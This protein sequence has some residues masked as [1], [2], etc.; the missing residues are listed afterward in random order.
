MRYFILHENERYYLDVGKGET[1]REVKDLLRK[2]FNLDTVKNHEGTS[3]VSLQL[4]YAGSN[5]EDEWIFSDIAIQTGSTLRCTLQQKVKPYL[6]VY[7]VYSTETI[8]F[9]KP[10]DVYETKVAD[11]RTMISDT[12][13]IHVSVFRLMTL[14]GIE[15]Y[16]CHSLKDYNIDIGDTVRMETW[17]GW[18]EFL[19]AAIKGQLTPT[20]KHVVNMNDDP[21]VAKY[22]L[23]VAL[24]IAAHFNFPQLAAQLLKSGARCD[25]PVGQHPVREWCTND[26]HPENAKTPVH[27][28]AQCGSL[29][30]LRQFLHHNY[31]CIL[32][33]DAHG[34][35][36]CNLARRYK[37]TECFKLLITE[38]F[39]SRSINGLTLN[40]YL[41]V[42]K[43][44]ERARDRAALFQK[45]SPNPVL[46]AMENR[47]CKK[48][49][50]GQIVQVDGFGRN[51]QESTT[52]IEAS[53]KM[54][55]P[56][57]GRHRALTGASSVN[58]S[59]NNKITAKTGR[60][61]KAQ[62]NDFIL[63]ENTKS[64]KS[65]IKQQKANDYK[66]S[67]PQAI[68]TMSPK[69][70]VAIIGINANE[71]PPAVWESR[72]QVEKLK[73]ENERNIGSPGQ[74]HEAKK[75][76]T[77]YRWRDDI[78]HE[79]RDSEVLTSSKENENKDS[80][81]KQHECRQT[82][83]EITTNRCSTAAKENKSFSS[84]YQKD[85][86][87]MSEIS[88]T[89][90]PHDFFVTEV[91]GSETRD[92][93]TQG[94]T[95]KSPSLVNEFDSL[96]TATT[97][98]PPITCK[99]CKDCFSDF[100]SSGE[101]SLKAKKL[102]RQISRTASSD[103][104]GD[105]DLPKSSPHT[106]KKRHT[107]AGSTFPCRSR[108]LSDDVSLQSMELYR[109]VTGRTIPESA[110]ASMDVAMTFSKKRWL[111]QIQMAIDLNSNT[112]KRQ[113][114]DVRNIKRNRSL[115]AETIRDHFNGCHSV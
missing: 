35:S 115:T 71:I 106:D 32:V 99:T 103:S 43:W 22:Q 86:E 79:T 33:K 110:R 53:I 105:S 41:R 58:L 98:M 66:L 12:T 100:Y 11:L 37:Q 10:F 91:F 24:F 57:V 15:M 27:E 51:M 45:H 97:K 85:H 14:N 65:G 69:Q 16:D 61:A 55:K 49:V 23:R 60:A 62:T 113:L 21:L 89:K 54:S 59:S 109:G 36:P 88:D 87:V 82:M 75:Q 72:C 17:N 94:L 25:E 112:F 13:G 76:R 111:Q 7:C 93:G 4:T 46:L 20:M 9:T 48:A 73:L 114:S 18:G 81:R 42:R 64:R 5:L 56:V 38:Q 108:S 83:P 3:D 102:S 74:H 68:E 47:S 84:E 34:L 44:S 19:K 30:C 39:R 2:K 6:H 8:T 40:V 31:A 107:I 63:H 96:A 67:S 90:K 80:L 95:G 78:S 77:F 70:K 104:G 1:V 52:K 50:V 26:T 29:T 28:A 101:I 92:D